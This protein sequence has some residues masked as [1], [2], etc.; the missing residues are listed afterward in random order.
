MLSKIWYIAYVEKPLSGH[1]PKNKKRQTRLPLELQKSY[2][3]QKYHYAAY[4]N[5]RVGHDGH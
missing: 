4:R 3:K 5:G 1:Y 2:S